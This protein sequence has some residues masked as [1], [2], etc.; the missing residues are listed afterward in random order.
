M[1]VDHPHTILSD[2]KTLRSRPCM[3]MITRKLILPFLALL[4]GSCATPVHI[5]CNTLLAT[6][7]SAH[8]QEFGLADFSVQA[9]GFGDWCVRQSDA[10]EVSLVTHPF[11]GRSTDDIPSP[12]LRD[13]DMF[14]LRAMA[15]RVAGAG[16]LTSIVRNWL[17]TGDRFWPPAMGELVD[18]LGPPGH[19]YSLDTS[20]VNE[21][22]TITQCVRFENVSLNDSDWR[23]SRSAFSVG[24][25]CQHPKKV[26]LLVAIYLTEH[27]VI[28]AGPN[29]TW[30]EEIRTQSLLPFFRSLTFR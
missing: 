21:P 26:D 20:V 24:F 14:L 2:V 28:G 12:L 6:P 29:E 23:Y 27:F 15:V 9:P 8:Q 7:L 4:A 13:E 25:V 3:L 5:D 17:K 30:F 1:R 22:S 19:W 10:N 11:L 18:Q 16:Q